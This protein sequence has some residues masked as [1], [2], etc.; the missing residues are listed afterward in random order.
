[1]E[2]AVR[3]LEWLL[4]ALDRFDAVER[5]ENPRVEVAYVADAANYSLQ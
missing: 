2:L 4:D 3:G 1:M 5:L